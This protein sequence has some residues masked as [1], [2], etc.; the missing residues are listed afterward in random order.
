MD[1]NISRHRAGQPIGGQFAPARKPASGIHL[2]RDRMLGYGLLDATEHGQDPVAYL[3]AHTPE[4]TEG[5]MDHI[6][7]AAHLYRTY[8]DC[9]GD[10]E[11]RAAGLSDDHPEALV[12]MSDFEAMNEPDRPGEDSYAGVDTVA[13]SEAL[14]QAWQEETHSR[15]KAALD[16]AATTQA[17]RSA[18]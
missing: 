10:G 11:D 9:E 4:L 12:A 7:E 2:S 18:A 6:A 17:A 3:R 1:T 16:R 8:L 15:M 14:A 13:Y 5:Q